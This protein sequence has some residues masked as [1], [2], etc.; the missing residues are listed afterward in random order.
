MTRTVLLA[1]LLV[2]PAAAT[3]LPDA[4]RDRLA[5]ARAFGAWT[6]PL[7]D[8]TYRAGGGRLAV[9]LPEYPRGSIEYMPGPFDAPRFVRRVTGDF[10][11]SVRADVP[12][13]PDGRL[14]NTNGQSRFVGGGLTAEDGRGN[15]AGIRKYEKMDGGHRTAYGSAFRQANGG[16]GGSGTGAQKGGDSRLFLRLSRK[17]SQALFATSTDGTTWRE[18]G[19]QEVGWDGPVTVGL[20]AENTTGVAVEV[21]FDHFTFTEPKN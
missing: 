16:G 9:R 18:Y 21:T 17:G 2:V 20:I 19:K 13:Q 8:C 12:H 15:R 11:A 1:L 7:G 14:G 4:E 10:V 3:P 6:D 5:V